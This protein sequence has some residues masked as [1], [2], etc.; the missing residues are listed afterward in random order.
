[1]PRVAAAMTTA[2][3]FP[4]ALLNAFETNERINQYLLQNLPAG[5]WRVPAL[6]GKGREI[7]AIFAHMHNVR[8][9]WLK[10]T[11]A[12]RIPDQLDR[13]NCTPQT[14]AKALKESAKELLILLGSAANSDGKVKGFKPDVVGFLGY[15]VSHD[16]HHRG[17]ISMLARQAGHPIPQKA[18]FG[19][20]EWGSRSKEAGA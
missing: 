12:A 8:L 15:L 3:S 18:M 7:A 17:Q 11:K 1:M 16:A 9:M 20:W 14:T 10:A 4:A 13:L 2:F 6:D 5:A 19:V